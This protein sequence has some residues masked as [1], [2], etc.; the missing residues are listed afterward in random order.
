MLGEGLLCR[1]KVDPTDLYLVS[2]V[3][4]SDLM[5]E[6][7]VSL[8]NLSRLAWRTL[9]RDTSVHGTK[10]R[11]ERARSTVLQGQDRCVTSPSFASSI[12]SHLLSALSDDRSSLHRSQRIALLRARLPPKMHA[13]PHW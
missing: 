2:A 11:L 1:A 13:L 12:Q 5:T 8:A 3:Q 10:G 9:S 4:A 6:G 7:L